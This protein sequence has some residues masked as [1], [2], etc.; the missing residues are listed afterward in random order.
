MKVTKNVRGKWPV[1][2]IINDH[3][4]SGFKQPIS[5]QKS[6]AAMSAG[7]GLAGGSWE[8][9]APCLFQLLMAGNAP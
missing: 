1:V 5:S 6:K 7:C 4:P 8:T 9:S 3:K 2:V